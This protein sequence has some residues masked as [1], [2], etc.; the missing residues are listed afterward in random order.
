MAFS[1][2]AANLVPSDTNVA[3]DVF[4]RDRQAGRTTRVSVDGSGV[5][6]NDDSYSASISGDGRCVA[7]ESIAANL[8]PA[9]TNA[10]ADV[11]V[12]QWLPVGP[13][14]FDGDGLSDIAV[15]RPSSGVWYLL[16]SGDAYDPTKYKAY[17]WGISTDI[18]VPGDYDGDGKTD[19]AV[20]RPSTGVWYILQSSDG[21]QDGDAWG[22]SGDVVAGDFDGDGKTDIAFYRPSSGI[23]YILQSSDGCSDADAMGHFRRR[24]GARGLRRG[25]EDGHRG[26][27]SLGRGLVHPAVLRR[28]Q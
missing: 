6:G 7:F 15:Y 16:Q 11:F 12:R 27:A 9:D 14:D 10:V 4:V 19:I 22:T 26:L 8:V 23:W 18:P 20:R 24:A 28:V 2:D 3:T 25:R 1:S 5:Q 17:L 21:A 13:N